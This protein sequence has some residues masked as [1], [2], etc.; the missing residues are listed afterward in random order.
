MI[1]REQFEITTG[2]HFSFLVR[3]RRYPPTYVLFS[4]CTFGKLSMKKLSYLRPVRWR[5]FGSSREGDCIS[6][7]A[8]DVSKALTPDSF[9]SFRRALEIFVDESFV[10]FL[11]ALARSL[12]QFSVAVDQFVRRYLVCLGVCFVCVTGIPYNIDVCID[13]WLALV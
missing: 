7:Y 3:L 4:P 10:L 2:G 5:A 9:L 6:P 8:W 12:S 1:F 13:V 11:V